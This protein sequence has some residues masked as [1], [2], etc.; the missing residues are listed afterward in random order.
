MHSGLR[1]LDA[2]H[3]ATAVRLKSVISGILTFDKE[4]AAAAARHDVPVEA[5]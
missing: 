5:I 4:L 2:L 1:T 3:L